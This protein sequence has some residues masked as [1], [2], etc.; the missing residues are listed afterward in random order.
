MAVIG[1]C[2]SHEP[3]A[4]HEQSS[5]AKIIQQKKAV[6]DETLSKR[7]QLLQTPNAYHQSNSMRPAIN[8]AVRQA[9][10]RA[11]QTKRDNYLTAARVSFTT[12]AIENP[13]LSSI[14]VHL[15]DIALLV[16][17][18]NLAIQHYQQAL[19]VN[20]HNYYAANRLGTLQRH[21]GE[22]EQA[23]LSYLQ[24][25]ESW[26]G[27]APAY[28]NLAILLDLYLGDKQKALGYYQRYL[29]L[30]EPELDAVEKRMV[31][32]WIFDLQSQLKIS[33]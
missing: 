15:G 24:A 19:S 18:S 7:Q 29:L 9:I 8:P 17:D 14:Q 25:I 23:K 12:L 20:T 33:E 5:V 28:R 30:A 1:G 4:S 6:T 26:P 13:S 21:A 10:N 22:F 3:V 31:N 32:A 27:F 2:A 11:L 16:K